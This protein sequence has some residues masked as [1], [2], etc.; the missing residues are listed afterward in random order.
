MEAHAC[1]SI[2]LVVLVYVVPSGSVVEAENIG[3]ERTWLLPSKSNLELA[4]LVL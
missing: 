1:D 4:W 3:D 2:L